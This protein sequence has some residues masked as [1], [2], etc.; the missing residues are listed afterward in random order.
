MSSF[1]VWIKFK[2][3]R[4]KK[5]RR[6]YGTSL[7]F[8]LQLRHVLY[9]LLNVISNLSSSLC[10]RPSGI[11]TKYLQL[12]INSMEGRKKEPTKQT[13]EKEGEKKQRSILQSIWLVV[14][15]AVWMIYSATDGS[16]CQTLKNLRPR[17]SISSALYRQ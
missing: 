15:E 7:A 6:K 10:F 2:Q 12:P 1:D 3:F 13:L 4:K 17:E 14:P 8:Q 9:S 5:R 11:N 16:V